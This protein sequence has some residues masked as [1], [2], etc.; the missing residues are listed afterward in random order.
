MQKREL[1]SEIAS[2][3][4]VVVHRAVSAGLSTL[5]ARIESLEVRFNNLPAV[6]DGKDI[7]PELVRMAIASEVAR[8]VAEIP[9]PKD[10]ESAQ[11]VDMTVVRS[12]IDDSVLAAV[13][14]LPKPKDGADGRDGKDGIDGKDGA[15]GERGLQGES[16]IP[17]F[18]V[19]GQDGTPGKD[20]KDG[21]DADPELIRTF[22]REEVETRVAAIP[23]PKDGTP[24]KDGK[25]GRDGRDAVS[26][27]GRD[28]E[29]GRDA[30]EIDILPSIDPTKSYPRGTFASYNGGIIRAIRNTDPVTKGLAESGWAVIVDGVCDP[31]IEQLED[32]R[33]IAVTMRLTSGALI[34]R[35]FTLPMMIYRGIFK[36]GDEYSRGDTVTWAG[37]TWHCQAE[38]TKAKPG[39][40][41]TEWKLAV[42]RGAA[43]KDGNP[44]ALP[45]NGGPVKL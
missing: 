10:G 12:M 5:L 32:L 39:E 45:P 25:D 28:G 42:K 17:G 30:L 19:A 35:Q 1:L 14:A 21:K 20:G 9:R 2:S 40:G 44:P 15:P 8:Q 29:P 31:S 36:D 6:R 41:S 34:T 7:D 38:S 18:G 43:G 11:P 4:T 13:E 27:P 33:T 3:V 24:G 37:S 16:G 23:V 26:T 22:V